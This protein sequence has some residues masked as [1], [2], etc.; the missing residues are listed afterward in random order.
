MKF[1][2]IA[3]FSLTTLYPKGGISLDN[4][5]RTT[6]SNNITVGQKIIKLSKS[7]MKA[8]QKK[9]KAQVDSNIIRFY[10]VKEKKNT[11][12]YAV[13]VTQIVRSKKA[14]ILYL[15]DKNKKIKNIEIITFNEPSEYKPFNSWKKTFY[16]KTKDDDLRDRHGI[17]TI[18]G[19]TLTARAFSHAAR[20]AL[21]IVEQETK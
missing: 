18:S 3:L 1:L 15:V 11:V 14:S 9:A 20:V 8:L 7:E 19:A 13:L 10:V 2:I 4:I 16:G 5:F 12:G 21:A 17:P 6:F